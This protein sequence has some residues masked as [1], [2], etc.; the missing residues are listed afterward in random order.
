MTDNTYEYELVDLSFELNYEIHEDDTPSCVSEDGDSFSEEHTSIE[1]DAD[2][3]P[4][5]KSI[6]EIRIRER[7][8][9]D[10]FYKWR[11]QNEERK[12]HNV[13]LNDYIYVKGISVI[14]AKEHSAKSYLSTKAVF[15]IDQVLKEAM[16]VRRTPVKKDNKNQGKFS[17]MLV[18]V[19]R[20]EDI[21]TIKLT[22]GVKSSNEHIEYGI[23]TLRPGQPLIDNSTKKNKK[24][25]SPH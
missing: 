1:Y 2:G 14:E 22:V 20:Q 4:M 15:L 17:Y 19:Y 3:I 8:I 25:R 11:E 13:A 18:M 10:F 12:I 24:K 21:G 23:S 9:A 6:E 16:P 7:M 5:G